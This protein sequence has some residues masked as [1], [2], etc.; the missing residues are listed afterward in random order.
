ML[1]MIFNSL[2]CYNL[3]IIGI[4][5]VTISMFDKKSQADMEVITACLLCL[6]VSYI[7]LHICVYTVYLC[8][9]YGDAQC[10]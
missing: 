5:Y 7:L 4:K 10:L 6:N 2:F 1:I 8:A 9:A 3:C